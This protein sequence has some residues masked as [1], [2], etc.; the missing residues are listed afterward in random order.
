MRKTLDVGLGEAGDRGDARR[1][2]PGQHLGFEPV[3]P[4]RVRRDV[5][6]ID[7]PVAR[8]DVHDPERQRRV[9]ADADLQMPVS[10]P[11]GA[12]LARIDRRRS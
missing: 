12:A 10:L 4:G 2:K 8:Q 5:V 11:R 1:R 7:Q 9:G 6:A 3:E